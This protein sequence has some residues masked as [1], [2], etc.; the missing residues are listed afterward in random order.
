MN[1]PKILLVDDDAA[2]LRAL[3]KMLAQDYQLCVADGGSEALEVIASESPDL[4]LLDLQMP[5]MDGLQVLGSIRAN[6]DTAD[7]LVIILTG[8]LCAETEAR[9]LELG[10]TDYITKP[11]HPR[12]VQARVQ[13]ALV[14]IRNEQLN[15]A[16]LAAVEMLGIAGHFKD[17]DTGYHVWRMAD[18]AAVLAEELGVDADEVKLLRLAA[19][20]H[21]IGKVGIPDAVMG[22]PGALDEAESNVMKGHVDI[23][24]RILQRGDSELFRIAATMALYHHERWDGQGYPSGLSGADIPLYARIA[25]VADV[26]DA[27]TT[28]RPYKQNWQSEEAFNYIVGNRCEAFDPDVVDALLRRKD[29]ILAIKSAYSELEQHAVDAFWPLKFAQSGFGRS[30]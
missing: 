25:A 4:V 19:T 17:N 22:K 16:H 12:V 20:M 30:E 21:D 5:Q 10:A 13:N 15:R 3:T 14:K 8:T 24:Y 6:P 23:G 9:A 28:E 29:Q 7:L 26:F 18:Y 1:K 27:L 11:V 2:V